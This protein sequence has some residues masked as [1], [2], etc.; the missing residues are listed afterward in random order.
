MGFA[1]HYN[2]LIYPYGF[3]NGDWLGP[4]GPAIYTGF[5]DAPFVVNCFWCSNLGQPSGF[6]FG[7]FLNA[8]LFN[9]GYGSNGRFLVE[10]KK[11]LITEGCTGTHAEGFY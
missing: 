5:Y 3:A 9:R 2:T 10:Q 8:F 1:H 7:L 6:W 4:M 11:K